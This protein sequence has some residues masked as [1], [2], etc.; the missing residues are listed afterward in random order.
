VPGEATN[1][2]FDLKNCFLF[3]NETGLRL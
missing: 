3:D 1:V 2:S